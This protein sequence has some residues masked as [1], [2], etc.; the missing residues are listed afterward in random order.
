MMSD[1]YQY[2]PETLGICRKLSRDVLFCYTWLSAWYIFDYPYLDDWLISEP[3]P[4]AARNILNTH[5]WNCQVDGLSIQSAEIVSDSIPRDIV[6]GH[7]V[8]HCCQYP[9]TLAGHEVSS[10]KVVC[11][12]DVSDIPSVVVENFHEL[13]QLHNRS[14]PTRTYPPPP[15]FD[16]PHPFLRLLKLLPRP[17]LCPG[18]L[19]VSKP[20]EDPLPSVLVTT[21]ASDDG[22]RI[23]Y[24]EGLHGKDGGLPPSAG[25]GTSVIRS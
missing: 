25:G 21:D 7:V 4:Q 18:L 19:L 6:V 10:V 2:T 1:A 14:G 23:H 13:P 16:V 12:K 8:G 15:L 24:F 5:H 3:S 17:W 9:A 20:W 22:C 11:C